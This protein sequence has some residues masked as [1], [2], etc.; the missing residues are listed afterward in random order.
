MF[1]QV[2]PRMTAPTAAGVTPNSAA[3]AFIRSPSSY[4]LRISVTTG[5]VSLDS[6]LFS[7][8]IQVPSRFRSWELRSRVP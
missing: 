3:R 1:A 6:P 4:R 5:Q 7:P 2:L 8:P